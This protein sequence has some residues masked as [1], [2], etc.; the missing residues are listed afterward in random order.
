MI[1]STNRLLFILQSAGRVNLLSDMPGIIVF[2]RDQSPV[3]MKY[4]AEM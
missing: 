2:Q 4:V 3:V 1:F